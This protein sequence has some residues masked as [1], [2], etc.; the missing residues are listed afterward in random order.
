MDN[1][2]GCVVQLFL[3]AHRVQVKLTA[4]VDVSVKQRLHQ[5]G[6]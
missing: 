1:T 5:E 6:M 2:P 4:F 3:A